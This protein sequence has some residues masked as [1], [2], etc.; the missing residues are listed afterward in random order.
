MLSEIKEKI[1]EILGKDRR[2]IFGYL[3]GSFLKSEDFNDIDIAL[4]CIP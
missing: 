3:F 4:Y 2:V 1:P